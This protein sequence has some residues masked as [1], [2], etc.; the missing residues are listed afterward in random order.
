MDSTAIRRISNAMSISFPGRALTTAVYLIAV[1]GVKRWFFRAAQ[2]DVTRC[3]NFKLAA[4]GV[5]L[6]FLHHERRMRS[7]GVH[8]LRKRSGNRHP[9]ATNLP[10]DSVK[11]FIAGPGEEHSVSG[12]CTKRQI[13]ISLRVPVR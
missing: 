9:S 2:I 5:H 11:P 4:S 6:T 3:E 8:K 13:V 7:R 12:P 10:R 1:N